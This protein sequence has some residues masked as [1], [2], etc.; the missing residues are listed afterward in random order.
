MHVFHFSRARG[1]TS[2]NLSR[3]LPVSLLQL[4]E[5]TNEPLIEGETMNVLRGYKKD[6]E[7]C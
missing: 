2:E 3:P 5:C 6:D 1:P 7:D 4:K